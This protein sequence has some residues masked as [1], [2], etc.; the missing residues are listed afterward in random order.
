MKSVLKP[1]C[2]LGILVCTG[3]AGGGEPAYDPA[4]YSCMLAID[5]VSTGEEGRFAARYVS[6]NGTASLT[7]TS[8]ERL[9][10]LAFSFTEGGCVL[11]AG[12]SA[13][14]LSEDTAASLQTLADLLRADPAAA[15]DRK[16]TAAGTVLIYDIGQVTLDDSGFP[17]LAET[18]DG[19]RASVTILPETADTTQNNPQESS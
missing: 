14:P 8:P 1:L 7:V 12:E 16:N 19:R 11:S 2:L 17:V 10:G 15:S 9:A 3:C 6:E 5:S 13:V 4:A 18:A